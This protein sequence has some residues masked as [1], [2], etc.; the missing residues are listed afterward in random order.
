MSANLCLI[1]WNEPIGTPNCSRCLA[2]SSV[3]S[4]IVCAVPTI[5]SAVAT[6]ASSIAR[7]SAGALDASAVAEHAVAL[8]AHAVEVDVREPAAAVERVHAAW[9]GSPRPARRP[10]A[11]RR[12][13]RCRGSRATTTSSSTAS[14]STT[15]RFSPDST[16]WSPSNDD[17]RGDRGGIER[18]A[19]LGDRERARSTRPR[20]PRRG[21]GRAARRC[22]PRARRG[23]TA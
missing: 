21:S 20:R 23:R 18:A 7:R 11:R 3:T 14:P 2:Y 15:K 5:S 6:V 1:A 10:R 16:A 19:L 13:R 22:R 17:R 4:K 12:R 9:C 8:D